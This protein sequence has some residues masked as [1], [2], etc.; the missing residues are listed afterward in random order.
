MLHLAPFKFRSSDPETNTSKKKKNKEKDRQ[1]QQNGGRDDKTLTAQTFIGETV[2][3]SLKP[4]LSPTRYHN[5]DTY[6]HVLT[7][8]SCPV[9]DL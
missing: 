2:S 9:N 8:I 7:I 1:T 6:L 5:R 4:S 3:F